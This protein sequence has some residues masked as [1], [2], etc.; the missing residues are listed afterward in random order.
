[1]KDMVIVPQPIGLKNS[2]DSTRKQQRSS[3]VSGPSFAQ[4]LQDHLQTTQGLQFSRHAQE[5]MS[6]RGIE[7]NAQDLQRLSQA[8]SQVQA[9]GGKDSLVLL[10]DN[11][12]VVSVPNRTVVTVVDQS[13]L[14]DNVFT[15]IDSA[16]IA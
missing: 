5:R 15:N 6:Q 9:K 1:M 11:A 10:D 14:K 16:I 13:H 8:V 7:M 3:A 4:V 2:S 12:M